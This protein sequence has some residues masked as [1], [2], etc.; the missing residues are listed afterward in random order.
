MESN[1]LK[2]YF[3]QPAIFIRLPSGGR[4]WP[5]NSL[6]LPANGEL[7]VLPMTTMDEIT[8]RTPDALFNGQA[9][10]SVIE[11]CIPHVK[12]AWKTPMTDIDTLLIAIRIATYGHEMDITSQ[13]PACGTEGDYGIDLRMV[14]E[15]ISPANYDEPL[16]LA[17]LEL[18][19][20]PMTYQDINANN[21]A[22][23]EDQK[24]MQA[25][26]QADMPDEQKMQT[27][28]E[29]LKKLT[30]MT[31]RALAQNIAMIRTPQAQ[32]TEFDHINEWLMNCDKGQFN[33]VKDHV[34]NMRMSSEVK[35]VQIKCGNCGHQHDQNFTLDMTTFFEDA[36]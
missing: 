28:S 16:R 14:M 30:A 24:V 13:C 31:A 27:I 2:Q 11:S 15:K 36:S 10:V 18:W 6:D 35:P 21:L 8:Y 3:R 33:A 17:D 20:R 26:D 5:P 22:Q 32:V 9:V 4:F 19:F 34:M 7:P 29:V 23:F 12:S 1:P 25:L